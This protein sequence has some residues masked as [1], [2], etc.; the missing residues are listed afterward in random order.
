[1]EA[2]MSFEKYLQELGVDTSAKNH[3]KFVLRF[4]SDKLGKRSFT[5]DDII[6]KNIDRTVV[7]YMYTPQ[8]RRQ[9]V[10]P[11]ELR[12]KLLKFSFA[13]MCN[14]GLL[15]TCKVD[16]ITHYTIVEL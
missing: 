14:E 2:R 15:R 13:R 6:R 8:N 7:I 11:I 9:L 12:V 5:L 10:P 3:D 4:C 1:M 16:N